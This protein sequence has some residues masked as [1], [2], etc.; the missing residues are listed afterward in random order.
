MKRFFASDF[1]FE[2]ERL[3]LFGR[4]TIFKNSNDFDETL[5]SNWNSVV[6]E[7]DVVYCLGDIS[8]T[9]KGLS[10]MAR[11]NGIKYLI[12]GNYDETDTAKYPVSDEILLKYFKKIYTSAY[13]N[14]NNEKIYLNHYPKNG[15]KEFFNI[16]GH[17]HDKWK[18]Q[19]NMINV[20]VDAWNFY[21]V[22]EE[23]IIF[24]INGI[25]KHYDENVFAGELDCNTSPNYVHKNEEIYKFDR[26][27][28]PPKT[29]I[30]DVENH[31]VFLA[32]PIQGSRNWQNEIVGKLK[33]L[34]PKN[35]YIANPRFVYKPDS[36]DYDKQ[37][38]WETEYLTRAS[39]NGIILFWLEKEEF[40]DPKRSYAQTTRFELATWLERQNN[41]KNIKICIGI[42]DDF[43]GKKYIVKKIKEEYPNINK[44][45][46]N[47]DS[48]L[49]EVKNL[50][51]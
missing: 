26:L 18:V 51:K 44:I 48:L 1:H 39:I 17:I 13:I 46:N 5:I 45:H 6:S 43:P 32:G 49:S 47:I 7:N 37:V 22:S 29:T 24:T 40:H 23:K 31:Y 4:D 27:I 15:K 20:G 9:E 12:K 8:Q 25:R 30:H 28:Y 35:Y 11:C 21:P 19:R 50:V 42:H 10:K 14:I 2:D 38:N 36:F 41:N 3:N 34:L 33:N 16:V